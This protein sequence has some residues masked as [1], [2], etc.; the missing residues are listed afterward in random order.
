[1]AD[2]VGLAIE[3]AC[4]QGPSL[5]WVVDD[6]SEDDTPA[7]VAQFSRLYSCLRYTRHETKTP[8][9]VTALR[10]I[11]AM[12][13]PGHVIG[14]AAD[15]VILPGLVD[16]VRASS[17]Y[18]A[19]FAHYSCERDGNT[20]YVTHPYAEVT[21]VH[22]ECMRHRLRWHQPTETGIGSSLR[23][24]VLAWL[25]DLGWHELGPHA[26]SIG[27][28]AAAYVHGAVYWPFVGAHVSIN[29]NSYGQQA[30]RSD[31]DWWAVKCR[32]FLQA[33]G[34]DAHTADA[35]VVRRCYA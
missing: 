25:W 26:D 31:R 7:V 30:A 17:L 35:L 24:D 10:Q 28:A 29:P 34:V 12:L 27:A 21:Y 14:L 1:M 32:S 9:H 3:S 33:A 11:H 19:M 16:A 2:T 20:W 22:G 5:V 18:P 8:C 6:A 23:T 13:P 4:S 15:D